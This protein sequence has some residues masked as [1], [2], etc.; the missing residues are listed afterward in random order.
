ML[1]RQTFI[2]FLAN[3]ITLASLAAMS[4]NPVVFSTVTKINHFDIDAE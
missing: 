1:H 2:G 3:L 4:P